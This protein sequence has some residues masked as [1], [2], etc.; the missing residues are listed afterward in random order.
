M[1]ATAARDFCW[2]R[3]QLTAPRLTPARPKRPPLHLQYVE[4]SPAKKDARGLALP[5]SSWPTD[6]TSNFRSQFTLYSR[7][8]T[9]SQLLPK[10]VFL[11][12]LISHLMLNSALLLNVLSTVT[13]FRADLVLHPTK[14]IRD[15]RPTSCH[16]RSYPE[17]ESS[18]SSPILQGPTRSHLAFNA[19]FSVI[20][21]CSLYGHILPSGP[22]LAS[23]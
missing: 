7:L 5:R 21:E 12:V 18:P 22:C 15:S 10:N 2:Q 11:I 16:S 23:A 3:G 6:A 4:K 14:C 8:V 19:Q 13:S 1:F 17:P 20:V 9:K